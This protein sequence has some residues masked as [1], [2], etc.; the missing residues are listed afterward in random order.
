MVIRCKL[1]LPGKSITIPDTQYVLDH[2]AITHE[3]I[4]YYLILTADQPT[5]PNAS[6]IGFDVQ[7]SEE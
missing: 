7:P 6:A 4:S 5:R 3:D 2:T 1:L